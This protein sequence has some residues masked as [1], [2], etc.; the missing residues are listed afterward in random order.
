MLENYLAAQ[1]A[2]LWMNVSSKRS[3]QGP[4]KCEFY[5]RCAYQKQFNDNE[6]DVPID[7]PTKEAPPSGL[8]SCHLRPE[9]ANFRINELQTG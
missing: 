2:S 9:P 5:G 6:S 7:E 8:Q 3:K 4:G 1:A